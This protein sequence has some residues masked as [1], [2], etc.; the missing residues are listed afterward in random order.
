M[1]EKLEINGVWPVL[2]SG[3]LEEL[4]C[5]EMWYQGK[6]EESANVIYI[7]VNGSW[8]RLYFDYGIIFWR[9]DKEGPKEYAMPEYESHF[10]VVDVGR[11]YNLVNNLIESVV[12]HVLPK[13]SEIIFRLANEK[14][15]TFSNI[16][17][18]T[19]YET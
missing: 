1:D 11:K 12:G 16:E 6:V 4:L 18:N 10:N 2:E 13:G 19:T 15:I 3:M 7:K 17:D 5:S 8:H 14:T 9:K